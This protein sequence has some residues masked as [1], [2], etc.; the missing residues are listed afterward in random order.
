MKIPFENQ[1]SPKI[2]FYNFH[3]VYE[4]WSQCGRPRIDI[5]AGHID[6]QKITIQQT[7]V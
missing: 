5:A 1:I 7:N 4:A 6:P 3:I 2:K